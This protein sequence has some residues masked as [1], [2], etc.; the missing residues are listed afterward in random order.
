MSVKKDWHEIGP[1]IYLGLI[2]DVVIRYPW[3]PTINEECFDMI[4]RRA[5]LLE[6]KLLL[7]DGYLLHHPWGLNALIDAR[8]LL[9][10]LMG[11]G[12]VVMLS[13]NAEIDTMPEKAAETVD[14]YKAIVNGP[15][16]THIKEQLKRLRQSDGYQWV[17]WPSFDNRPGFTKLITSLHGTS[18][19]KLGIPARS[20]VSSL[21]LD[22][23]IEQFA[24]AREL[25]PDTG[26]RTV[27]E[28]VVNDIQPRSARMELMHIGNEAYHYNMGLCIRKAAHNIDIG[29]A[30]RLSP[31]F[32]PRFAPEVGSCEGL[33]RLR[34]PDTLYR[35]PVN[36]FMA[37]VG[38]AE[39]RTTK[40]AYVR[41]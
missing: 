22:R 26:A 32:A 8:T 1:A 27:W 34:L 17:K 16:W 31:V 40:Q 29:V 18:P 5:A 13:R 2:D 12:L 19:A 9:R 4:L 39:V 36:D 24:R 38:D 25:Q 28:K 6:R 20:Q 41:R 15:D 11:E 37:I 35:I 33:P 21:L 30:T 23:A 3:G 7:N 14:S 10:R